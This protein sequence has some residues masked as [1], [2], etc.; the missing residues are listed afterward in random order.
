MKAFEEKVLFISF[1][2]GKTQ[3][4]TILASGHLPKA[5]VVQICEETVNIKGM[6]VV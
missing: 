3:Y 4:N 6:W 2:I 5:L 1:H